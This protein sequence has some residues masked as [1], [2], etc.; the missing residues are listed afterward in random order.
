MATMGGYSDPD[1]CIRL[2]GKKVWQKAI[3]DA[4]PM[5]EFLLNM[6]DM[7][8]LMEETH[9]FIKKKIC[10]REVSYKL[11]LIIALHKKTDISMDVLLE[12]MFMYDED[13]TI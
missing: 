8:N 3:D 9:N 10:G 5:H 1:E 11:L 6:F 12:V 13:K 4:I 2:G 7:D